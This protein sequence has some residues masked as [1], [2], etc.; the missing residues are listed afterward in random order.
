MHRSFLG[1]SLAWLA[2]LLDIAPREMLATRLLKIHRQRCMLS[3]SNRARDFRHH[4]SA[5]DCVIL[6]AASGWACW[7]HC[8]ILGMWPTGTVP[9][10]LSQQNSR[11]IDGLSGACGQETCMQLH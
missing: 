5:G 8:T 6:K 2:T 10:G 7:N 3:P 9:A 1:D 4:R 11:G